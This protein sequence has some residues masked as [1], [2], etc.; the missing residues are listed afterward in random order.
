MTGSGVPS[1]DGAWGYSA[2]NGEGD[3]GKSAGCRALRNRIG[4]VF[5]VV[6]IWEGLLRAG[7]IAFGPRSRWSRDLAVP[8]FRFAWRSRWSR[9][10]DPASPHLEQREMWGTRV[11]RSI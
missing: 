2:M 8:A 9:T 1:G 6:R 7:R 11:L 10:Y 4:R 3:K 5:G